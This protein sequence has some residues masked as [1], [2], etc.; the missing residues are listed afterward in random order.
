[1]K[2]YAYI[3]LHYGAEYLKQAIQ[4]VDEFVEKILIL[5]TDKPSYGF[6]TAS[7]CP[8]TEGELQAIAS[9]AS[10]KVVWIKQNFEYE[11]AHRSYA[12]QFAEDADLL[13]ALDADEVWNRESLK[14]CLEFA[15]NA[16]HKYTGI[17]GFI[18]FWK[19]FN[20]ACYDGY[21]PIRITKIKANN[22]DQKHIGG[23]V[24]H[25]SCAQSLKMV[26]YKWEIHGH[27][28]ELRPDWME[29]Y[30]AWTPENNLL[31]LHPVAINLWNATP[32]DKEFLPD[33]MKTHPN[34]NKTLIE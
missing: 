23:K 18:N 15:Y 19:S 21:A 31:D 6:G 5:Y 2:V 29:K 7:P 24:Y 13:L 27:K 28:D 3:P 22:M 12:N 9:S 1:M 16:P 25:F 4:S 14:E 32:F 10:S 8:E 20:Y 30:L 11:G 26:K 33:F 34:Y 17:T